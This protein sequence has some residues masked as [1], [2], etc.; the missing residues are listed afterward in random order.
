MDF[1][2][3]FFFMFCVTQT[4]ETHIDRQSVRESYNDVRSDFTETNWYSILKIIIIIFFFFLF[5]LNSLLEGFSL[6]CDYYPLLAT[7]F[8]ATFSVVLFIHFVLGCIWVC[9]SWR[10]LNSL[11]RI[12]SML[13]R[14]EKGRAVY[15]PKFWHSFLGELVALYTG[16]SSSSIFLVIAVTWIVHGSE[17]SVGGSIQMNTCP[18]VCAVWW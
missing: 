1:F 12:Q 10:P 13:I 14:T 3:L 15:T 8:V 7:V 11:N 2:F 9:S 16:S 4:L 6:L 18:A 5:V 17:Q